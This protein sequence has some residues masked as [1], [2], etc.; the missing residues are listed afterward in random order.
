MKIL[1][2]ETIKNEVKNI[3]NELGSLSRQRL[4]VY[5]TYI[6][7]LENGRLDNIVYKDINEENILSLIDYF[8]ELHKKNTLK[9]IAIGIDYEVASNGNIGARDI[10]YEKLIS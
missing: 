7:P 6:A 1:N 10:Y 9:Y 5:S 4:Y 2:L 8:N 3:E